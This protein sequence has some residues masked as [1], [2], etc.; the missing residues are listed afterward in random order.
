MS[1]YG[2]EAITLIEVIE[3]IEIERLENLEQ[4]VFG[5][6]SPKLV[7]VT[8]PNY[9]FNR[10][11]QDVEKFILL[12]LSSFKENRP[13]FRHDDHKFEWVREE[14]KNWAERISTTFGNSIKK[15]NY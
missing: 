9:E 7:I 13:D 5:L 2:F 10:F 4:N 11:F 6:I 3:H 15:P 8:T 12:L 14:F 1:K